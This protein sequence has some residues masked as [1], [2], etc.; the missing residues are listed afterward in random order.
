MPL[1]TFKKCVCAN[2]GVCVCACMCVLWLPRSPH[3]HHTDSRHTHLLYGVQIYNLAS[4]FVASDLVKKGVVFFYWLAHIGLLLSVA[5]CSPKL[6][7]LFLKSGAY[8][9]LFYYLQALP[10]Y[11]RQPN[12]LRSVQPF[13]SSAN[14]RPIS[15]HERITLPVN[16]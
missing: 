3:S 12:C 8:L 11:L 1:G 13:T 10:L 5:L 7:V 14:P 15:S 6:R 16:N 2:V 4:Y 9:H